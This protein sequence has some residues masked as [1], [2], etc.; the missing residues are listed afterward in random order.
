MFVV[1]LEVL[2]KVQ[3]PIMSERRT[4]SDNEY[5]IEIEAGQVTHVRWGESIVQYLYTFI[6]SSRQFWCNLE[7]RRWWQ[8]LFMMVDERSSVD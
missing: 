8:R 1:V 2:L 3:V 6:H 4:R 5:K 7:S